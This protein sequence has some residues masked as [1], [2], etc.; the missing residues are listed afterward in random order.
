MAD[1]VFGFLKNLAAPEN[2]WYLAANIILTVALVWGLVVATLALNPLGYEGPAGP[3]GPAGEAGASASG[4]SSSGNVTDVNFTAAQLV[5]STT[6][7]PGAGPEATTYMIPSFREGKW[8][9]AGLEIMMAAPAEGSPSTLE[10]VCTVDIKRS[11]GEPVV[12]VDGEM[13]LEVPGGGSSF[14]PQ[15]REIPLPA[16][17]KN[18]LLDSGAQ[19]IFN[20]SDGDADQ[21]LS[22]TNAV[23]GDRYFRVHLVKA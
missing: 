22:T 15:F 4:V 12:D 21:A 20:V 23:G 19:I 14:S 18:L 9:I 16:S 8:K 6:F 2:G 1:G 10:T 13:R 7:D 5:A 3:A 17:A 11:A